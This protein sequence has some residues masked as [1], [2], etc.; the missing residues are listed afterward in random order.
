MTSNRG[1]GVFCV[2]PGRHIVSTDVTGWGY[3]RRT[4]TSMATA[5]M[6]GCVALLL[7]KFKWDG[8]NLSA[9]QLRSKVHEHIARHVSDRGPPGRDPWFGHGLVQMQA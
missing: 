1:D 3:R 9:R 7:A 6:S 2:A 4:G 5:F 8:P